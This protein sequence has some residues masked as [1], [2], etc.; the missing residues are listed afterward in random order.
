MF[1]RIRKSRE[2]SPELAS[3]LTLAT[4]NG[5][6]KLSFPPEI[7][8]SMR[9]MTTRLMYKDKLPP[10]LAFVSPLR[11]EGVTYISRAVAVTMANDL[12]ADVCV[13]ELNWWWPDTT[14]ELDST[15]G[16]LAAVLSGDISL[17]DAIVRTEMP[18]LAILP[19]GSMALEQ[20]PVWARHTHLKELINDLGGLFNHLV[21]DIPAI[22]ATNDSIPLASLANACC[23]VV[24]QG[25]T[26]AESA[27]LA[28]DEISHLQLA[29]VVMNKVKVSTPS[30]LLNL[31]PQD[32][33][34]VADL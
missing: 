23:L 26:S 3:P 14:L 30:W 1:K 13:V 16:G 5:K 34:P 17:D 22:L 12:N 31:I 9:Y 4:E 21:L 11:Q 28:L 33:G 19:S 8:N 6:A 10:R 15:S 2:Q 27:R 7:V 18:N 25:V 29:G 32:P 24:N 20:R